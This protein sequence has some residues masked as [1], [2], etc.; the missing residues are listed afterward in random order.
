MAAAA[1][2]LRVLLV[3]EN[4]AAGGQVYRSPAPGAGGPDSGIGDALRARLSTSG[5]ECRFGHRVWFVEPGFRICAVEADRAVEWHARFLI[6]SGGAQ[7]R[8]R[9]VPGW[10]LPGVIGL[11]GATNLLKAQGILPGHRVLVA[12]AGPLL[13]LVAA[14]ILKA[15][16]TVAGV[17]DASSRPRWLAALPAMA[18]RPDLL[19]RGAGWYLSLLRAGVPILH[20]HA[21]R[22]I[23]GADQV[24]GARAAP[25]LAT[26]EAATDIACDSVCYGFGLMPA[27]EMARLLGVPHDYDPALGGWFPRIDED[28]ATAVEN[29]F[30]CGDGAG[31]LGAAAATRQGT[32]TGRAV[33]RAAGKDALA[34][35]A[36][37]RRAK[38][39]GRFGAA[40]T[41]LAAPPAE[42]LAAIT[43]GTIVCR[44]E[45]LT[46]DTLDQ[47]VA[48]GAWT[49]NGLKAATRCGMGP[50]GGRI[51]ED[52]AA[53]LIG[54]ATGLS[55]KEIGQGSPRP[56]LRP[57]P[58]AA[59]AG[60][61]DYFA[62]PMP[63][64]APQ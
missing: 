38:Q 30:I 59:I 21:L 15:G 55:R 64:P 45:N 2:G 46:R 53:A 58:L 5:V 48:G 35:A 24:E 17:V 57:V 63:E 32:L 20:G 47:A 43:P 4:A 56:P 16:G 6:L 8:H 31:V 27:T 33:A 10:T 36:M 23:E 60:E 11:A 52:T 40:M 18:S 12:G 22:A 50:C 25:L 29:L 42:T 54:A 39:A 3:D 28:G 13:L 26:A 44:C 37:R 7:E 49:I 19:L 51:C 34:S 9:P 62:L 61:F 41:R 14:T 1:A